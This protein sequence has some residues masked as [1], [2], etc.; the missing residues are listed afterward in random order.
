MFALSSPRVLT[1]ETTSLISLALG[2][3]YSKAEF[4]VYKLKEME[5]IHSHQISEICHQFD[6]LDVNN[7][8]KI[9]LARLQEGN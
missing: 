1:K 7:S 4:V 9:T 2:V 3:M 6:Q 5:H 8:G